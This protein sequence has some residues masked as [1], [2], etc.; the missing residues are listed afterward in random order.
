MS[1]MARSPTGRSGFGSTVVYGPSREPLPP[2]RIT[3][4][5]FTSFPSVLCARSLSGARYRSCSALP[6][7]HLAGLAVDGHLAPHHDGGRRPEQN[8]QVQEEAAPLGIDDVEA[9]LL[10]EDLLD[11]VVQKVVAVEDPALL[12]EGDLREA[13]DAGPHAE[14]RAVVALVEHDEVHVLGPRADEAHLAD[15]HVP[16][17]GDLVDLELGQ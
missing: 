10:R 9:D 14:D 6:K 12:G 7:I 15:E 1:R 2:A 8:P 11:V 3:A 17:L 13:G 16:Q 5:F 4:L